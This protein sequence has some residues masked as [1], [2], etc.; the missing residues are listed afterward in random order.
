MPWQLLTQERDA[1]LEFVPFDDEGVLNLDSYDVLLRTRPK[2]V[3]FGHVS[4]GLGTINPAR[5]MVERAHAVGA[6]ALVA[7]QSPE[8]RHTLTAHLE[9]VAQRG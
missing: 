6:L 4:N 9:H 1:D 8:G 7:S 3:A 5:E 2:L